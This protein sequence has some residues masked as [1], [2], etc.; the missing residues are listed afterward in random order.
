MLR[1]DLSASINT[2]LE[3][4]VSKIDVQKESTFFN[5]VEKSDYRQQTNLMIQQLSL[6]IQGLN[7]VTQRAKI[8]NLLTGLT[9]NNI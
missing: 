3:E 5:E 9:E 2:E 7:F 8:Q 4:I 6:R 1:Q